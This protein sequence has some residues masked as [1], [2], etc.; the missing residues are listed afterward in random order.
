MLKKNDKTTIK[1]EDISA[2]GQ[3]IGKVEGA[4]IFCKN[5]VPGDEAVIKIIKQTKRSYI[6]IPVEITKKSEFR[7]EP[8]CEHFNKCGGCS[9]QNLSYQYQLDYKT[10]KVVD[11][12]NRLGDIDAKI[13]PCVASSDEYNYRN[14]AVF[15]LGN[16][17]GKIISGFY[18]QG[19]HNIVN[20]GSCD[21]QDK[22]INTAYSIVKNWIIRHEIS[23]YNEQTKF[24]LLRHIFLRL[25]KHDNLMV[26]LVAFEENIPHMNELIEELKSI[27]SFTNFS[28]N[29]N[30]KNSNVIL[31]DKTITLYGDKFIKHKI[32][33][34]TFKVSLQSF[35]QVNTA[36]CEK[37]YS[38]VM[39]YANI[40]E[41]DNVVDLFCGIGTLT[42]LAAKKAKQ[43]HGI[44]YVRSAID[45]AKSN[46][47]IN[48]IKNTNFIC[49]DCTIEYKKLLKRINKVNILIVD[50]PRKGLDEKL[51][52]TILDN[53]PK[54]IVYVSCDPGTL[55]RDLKLLSKR[56]DIIEATPFDMFPQTTHVETIT[57]MSLKK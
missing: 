23:I 24:G 46:A 13:Q 26:G 45:N 6:A 22:T 7:R 4:V 47:K 29:I 30:N 27:D 43:V 36:Q 1:I 35:L 52:N 3:G 56:Y 31:G 10:K 54:K 33:D 20:I 55:A 39:E 28:V 17:N 53:A 44:E 21:I 14:K 8:K 42:L 38:N 51:I 16:I 48:N 34:L 9:I 41:S 2:T 19:T 57:G 5:L 18:G 50:P 25:S 40:K 37:L 32:F 11:A 49:G 15:P 12:F